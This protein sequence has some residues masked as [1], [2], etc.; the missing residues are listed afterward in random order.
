MQKKMKKENSAQGACRDF[1]Q[2]LVL[3]HYAEI[4]A[5]D[6]QRLEA[7]LMDCVSC[8]EFLQELRAVLSSTSK[9][10]DPPQ[11]FWDNYSKEMSRKLDAV[12]ERASWRDLLFSF[13][14]PWP[15]RALAAT[16]VIVSVA[17]LT[18]R[19]RIWHPQQALSTASKQEAWM[20]IQPVA[21]NLE[22]FKTMD[23]LDSIDLLQAIDAKGGAHKGV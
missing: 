12:G 16:L 20:Q 13:F 3:Y 8:R 21:D 7:H 6:Y 17:A 10:D 22:F 9:P 18:L 4:T 1:E 15:V 19:E 5:K 14:H 2:D 23:L 11:S